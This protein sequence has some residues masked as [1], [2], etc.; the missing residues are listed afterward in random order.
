[1]IRTTARRAVI[2][3]LTAT[4]LTMAAAVPASAMP[5]VDD[6]PVTPAEPAPPTATRFQTPDVTEIVRGTAQP[7]PPAAVGDPTAKPR[8]MTT[9]AGVDVL[10]P[11]MS[12]GFALIVLAMYAGFRLRTGPGRALV[13]G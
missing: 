3:V 4:C 8:P 9:P 13:R 11:A 2:A 10:P 7:Q 12:G 5:A 1:M 6:G